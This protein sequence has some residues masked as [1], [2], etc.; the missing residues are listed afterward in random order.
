MKKRPSAPAPMTQVLLAIV[1]N[2][3]ART[4]AALK[5]LREDMFAAATPD[6]GRSI[7]ETGRHLFALRRMQLKALRPA[8][9]ARLPHLDPV[10]SVADLE[11]KLDATAQLVREAIAASADRDLL[12]PCA[13]HRA[14]TRLD[15]LVVRLNDYTNH[16]GDIRTLR[17]LMG[18]PV[19]TLSRREPT[20][21]RETRSTPLA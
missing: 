12:A 19:G 3:S 9:L 17:R 5:G 16:L 20:V 13:G 6:G 4:A 10:A 15:R 14:E 7:R 18:N 11:S 21:R 1:D 8:A 2:Q